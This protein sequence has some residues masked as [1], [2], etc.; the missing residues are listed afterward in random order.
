MVRER[1]KMIFSNSA[2]EPIVSVYN[3]AHV[4]GIGAILQSLLQQCDS[5]FVSAFFSQT[6]RCDP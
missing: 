4:L 2:F 6:H 3:M 1:L 5:E